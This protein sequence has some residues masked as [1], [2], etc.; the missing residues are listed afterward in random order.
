MF[1]FELRRKPDLFDVLYRGRG[2]GR[3]VRPKTSVQAITAPTTTTTTTVS[4]SV[5]YYRSSFWDGEQFHSGWG[6][7][8]L[9]TVDYWTLR[10]R[11]SELFRKNIYG[12]GITR[13]YLTNLI[14]TGLHLEATPQAVTLGL[15]EDWLAEW[16]ELA[17]SRFALWAANPKLCDYGEALT[18][19]ELQ[20]NAELEA[21]VSGDVLVVLR[22]D[23]RTGLPRIQLVS[24]ASVKTPLDRAFNRPGQN[25]VT[26][27]VELDDNGRHVAYHVEQDDGT[28]KR[29][30]ARG[31]KTGRR[32][33]W[34]LYG[35]D[36]RIGDVRG[37]PLLAIV[38]QSL[39]DLDRYRISTI[40]KAEINSMLAMFIKREQP[41][42][43]T[44]P[45]TGSG[46]GAVRVEAETTI[47]TTGTERSVHVS[48]HHPGMVIE[49]LGVGETPQAFGAQGTD[50]KFGDFEEAMTAAIAAALEMPPEIYRLAFSHNYSASQAANNEWALFLKR[51]RD[52]FANRFCQPCY[53]EWQLSE[54]QNGKIDAPGLLK[55]YWSVEQY[56]V[57]AAWTFSDWAGQIKLST[58]MLK[59]VKAYRE[60][61]DACVMTWSRAMREL[62]GMKFSTSMKVYRK[63][64]EL[65]RWARE[66]LA[67]METAQT[68]PMQPDEGDA[69]DEGDN[70]DEESAGAR[71]PGEHRPRARAAA[72]MLLEGRN[73]G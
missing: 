61:I 30:L 51:G 19:G 4:A 70:P 24:G 16:A 45:I 53:C 63:E 39:K 66:P 3:A 71:L 12:R 34:L 26:H 35:T 43:P 20:Y 28:Y 17:E 68:Q 64:A 1:G 32:L 57:Y 72:L 23:P 36:K 18:F 5:P 49:T 11:S 6:A 52:T 27:G 41:G 56:D 37:E 10:K 42:I 54:V 2:R 47:D 55:A 40:R 13:R 33:A 58:D 29:I 62:T 60:M 38:M 67:G 46:G 31:P 14:N 59:V 15:D 65:V 22:R 48:E 73:S 21:L 44:T 25:R 8:E 69:Q 9:L 7:T 50:E